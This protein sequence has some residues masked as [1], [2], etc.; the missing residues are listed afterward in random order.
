[1]EVGIGCFDKMKFIS[2]GNIGVVYSVVWCG[3][4]EVVIKNSNMN[5]LDI[6]ILNEGVIF[7]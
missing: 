6:Y 1:M 7:F 5:V 2:L 3:V 4:M